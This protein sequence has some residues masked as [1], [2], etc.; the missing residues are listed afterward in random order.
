V[1]VCVWGGGVMVGRGGDGGMEGGGYAK[2]TP[3]GCQ[4]LTQHFFGCAVCR[5]DMTPANWCGLHATLCCSVL[6]YAMPCCAVLN[7]PLLCCAV[8]QGRDPSAGPPGCVCP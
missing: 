5:A 2:E 8:L 3:A 1:C 6:C 7:C 4:T